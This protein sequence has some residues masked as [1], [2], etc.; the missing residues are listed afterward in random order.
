MLPGMSGVVVN[1]RVGDLVFPLGRRPPRAG[2]LGGVPDRDRY[3]ALQ[4]LACLGNVVRVLSGPAA[5]AE[6]T[7]VGK[8]AFVLVDFPQDGAR[9]CSRRATR[10]SCERTGR[11]CA[12][13]TS[14]RTWPRAAAARRSSTGMRVE[15]SDDGRLR[16]EVAAEMPAFT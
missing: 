11:G 2:R 15:R 9:R 12:S 5:G 16:V 3:Q 7:V 13:S 14:R 6:G 4:F 10:C 8:H 1:A